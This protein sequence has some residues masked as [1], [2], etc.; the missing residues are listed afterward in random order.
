MSNNMGEKRK[1]VLTMLLRFRSNEG[2]AKVELFKGSD[3][4]YQQADFV[5]Q[6]IDVRYRIRING[7]WWPKGDR[8]FFTKTEF[9]RL[10]MKSLKI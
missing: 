3:F 8:K 6:N 5:M 9:G 10:L 7:R 2:A 4:K 1:P